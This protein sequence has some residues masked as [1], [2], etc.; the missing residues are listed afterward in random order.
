MKKIVVLTGAG[1]SAESGLKTF[2]DH[3]G[4]WE[5]YKIEDVATPEAWQNNFKQ[6]LAFYDIRRKQTI[7]A[8]PNAAHYA[9]VSLEIKYKVHI[10]T[11][12]IDDLHE[13]A[14]STH[15]LHLHGEIRKARSTADDS[16]VLPIKGWK[17]APGDKCPYG[18][19]LRPHVVW[20]G[21]PVPAMG[22]AYNLISDT[23]IL[24]VVGT[25]LTVY[26]AAGLVE[27]AP[28]NATRF[29]IDP[30]PVNVQAGISPITHIKEKASTGLPALA[31]KLLQDNT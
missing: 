7:E 11:Q 1:I 22:D 14:G 20:F 18:S 12:N 5:Q 30:N 9:L 19:Q 25:S 24:I 8:V 27:M 10:I 31:E 2:R 28:E 26:P 3:D 4:L 13:R 29:L 6:V 17:L 16:V 15:I 23:D 21:E